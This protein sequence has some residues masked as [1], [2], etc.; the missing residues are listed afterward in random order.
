MRNFLPHPKL[1]AH[2]LKQ[3]AMI[4]MLIDHIAA[5][6]IYK[7]IVAAS[8]SAEASFETLAYSLSEIDLKTLLQ[9]VYVAMRA[10]GRL[11]FTL[12]CFLLV[13]GFHH[14]SSKRKYLQ[15]LLLFALIS[16]IPYDLAVSGHIFDPSQT[17]VFLTLALGFTMMS[18]IHTYMEKSPISRIK[19][20]II[21]AISEQT[22][23]ILIC[24]IFMFLASILNTDYGYMGIFAI[25]ILFKLPSKPVIATLLATLGLSINVANPVQVASLLSTIP[26]YLYNGQKGNVRNRYFFYV[27]YPAHLLVLTVVTQ[28]IQA[29]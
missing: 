16:E 7:C 11:S 2:N 9:S 23:S 18:L 19:R 8:V 29:A 5:I 15:R 14:T 10:I 17:N 13:E 28:L 27:F 26:I 24:C 6:I 12:Y 3:I 1:T 22:V 4:T 21:Y 25:Y 20:P